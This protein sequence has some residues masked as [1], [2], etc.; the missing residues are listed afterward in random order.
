METI[1]AFLNEKARGYKLTAIPRICAKQ[2]EVIQSHSYAN[3]PQTGNRIEQ[4]CYSAT[5][6]APGGVSVLPLVTQTVLRYGSASFPTFPN[7]LP[8]QSSLW[9]FS[10]SCAFQ[11]GLNREQFGILNCEHSK[12]VI[13]LSC[14][15]SLLLVTIVQVR[16]QNILLLQHV[17]C[18]YF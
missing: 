1:F 14:P 13:S 15:R 10:Q 17:T 4:L 9:L 8:S 2:I 11:M 12:A 3:S 6:W 16:R 7:L 5:S 18:S